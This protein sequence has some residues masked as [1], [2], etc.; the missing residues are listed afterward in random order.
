MLVALLLIVLQLYFLL[1]IARIVLE[2]IQS[3]ATDWRPHGAML[4]VCEAIYTPTDPPL[5]ALRKVVP[6]LPLGSLRLDL[7]PLILLL[8]ITLLMSLIRSFA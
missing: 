8:A 4:L 1:V 7:S 2:T 3:F 6:T 5:K